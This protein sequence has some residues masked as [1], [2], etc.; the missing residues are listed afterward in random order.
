MCTAQRTKDLIPSPIEN[1]QKECV[2]DAQ[3]RAVTTRLGGR[4][5]MNVLTIFFHLFRALIRRHLPLLLEELSLQR[6]QPLRLLR[7][8]ERFS[9]AFVLFFCK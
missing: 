2:S 5:C 1:A 4:H 3:M 7:L 8:S 6:G 9:S